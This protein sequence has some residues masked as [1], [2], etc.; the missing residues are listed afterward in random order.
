MMT[1]GCDPEFVLVDN[2]GHLTSANSYPFFNSTQEDSKIGCD[3]SG[4]PVEIRTAPVPT[5][6]VQLMLDDINNSFSRIARFCNDKNFNLYAGAY[7]KSTCIGGHIH[8]GGRDL[9]HD[10]RYQ[11]SGKQKFQIKLVHLLDTYFTPMSNFFITSEELGRRIRSSH[12]SYG[13]LGQYRR[14]DWGIEYRTPYSF[15]ISPLITKGLFS[16][17]CLLS[18]HYK[19]IKFN[20][21]LIREVKHYYMDLGE[22]FT[23]IRLKSIY[24]TI[25]PNIL[26]MMSWHSPNPKQN[27]SILSL[28]SLIERGRMPKTMNVL[29]NYNLKGKLSIP[30]FYIHY[31]D[32]H[33]GYISSLKRKIDRYVHNKSKGEIMIYGVINEDGPIIYISEQLPQIKN[34]PPKIRIIRT[35]V[36]KNAKMPSIGVSIDFTR[37]MNNKPDRK[38]SKFFTDYLNTLKLDEYV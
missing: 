33:Y 27:S 26:K 2:T 23:P 5:N 22:H 19:K 14:Q 11:S 38:Y 35:K 15:L 37:Y 6:K 31:S 17:A 7:K 10:P 13:V 29:T 18:S 9:T 25:K 4:T 1:I 21:K 8:F 32:K 20:D 24:K 28:F 34:V 16:L 30:E 12:G 36:A 3:G